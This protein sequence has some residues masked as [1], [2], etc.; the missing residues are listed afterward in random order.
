M[1]SRLH[2]LRQKAKSKK[3]KAPRKAMLFLVAPRPGF[4][5]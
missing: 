1:P 3:Q 2:S 4:E 5:P